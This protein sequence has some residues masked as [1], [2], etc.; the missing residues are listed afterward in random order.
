MVVSFLLVFNVSPTATIFA[1]GQ[2]SSGK[3]FTM[4]GVAEDAVE[5]IYKYIKLVR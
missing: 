4:R 3:T 5:D 2:T 1:Y